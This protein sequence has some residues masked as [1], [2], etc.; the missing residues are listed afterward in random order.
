MSFLSQDGASVLKNLNKQKIG[1]RENEKGIALYLTLVMCQREGRNILL[2]V[3]EGPVSQ[4]VK[5]LKAERFL[6]FPD[7]MWL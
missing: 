3:L 2:V 1:L 4:M 7:G 6:E 5:F